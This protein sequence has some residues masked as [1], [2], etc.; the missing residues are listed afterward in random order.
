LVADRGAPEEVFDE[1][2]KHF[3]EDEIAYLTLA[4][5]A[6]NGWN[7]INIGFRTEPGDYQPGEKMKWAARAKAAAV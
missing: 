4:I 7:R 3:S 6:I 5:V 1:V 2:R